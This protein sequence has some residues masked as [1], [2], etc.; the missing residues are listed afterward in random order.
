[1]TKDDA[2]RWLRWKKTGKHRG[3]HPDKQRCGKKGA[4]IPRPSRRKDPN[5]P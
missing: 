2:R 3:K 4:G 5:V 1:M